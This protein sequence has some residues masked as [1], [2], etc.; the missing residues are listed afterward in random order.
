[1]TCNPN[2]DRRHVLRAAAVLLA[3]SL[4]GFLAAVAFAKTPLELVRQ[5]PKPKFRSGHTLPPLT[6]WGYPLPYE[7]K[8]EMTENWGYALELGEC[9]T[10]EAI[11][12]LDDSKS[13]PAKVLALCASNPKRYPL[14]VLT[15]RP[16]FVP[17]FL[18][19]LPESAWCHDASGKRLPGYG[20][21]LEPRALSPEAPDECFQKAGEIVGE[22]LK[23][24]RRKAPIAIVLNGGEYGMP[25]FGFGGKIWKQD[26]KVVK[27]VG[28]RSWSQY[29]GE[30]RARHEM[31][32]FRAVCQQV[33]DRLLYIDYPFSVCQ[34]QNHSDDWWQWEYAY[35][36]VKAVTD[37][38]GASLY[39]GDYNSG[40]TG[41]NDMLTQ[42][43]N[44]VGGQIELKQPL[45]YN[46]LC[47]GYDRAKPSTD[48]SDME[49]YMGYLKCLYTAGTIGGVA[50]Y[51]SSPKGAFGADLGD[52]MPSWLAQQLTLSHAHALFSHLEEFLR[53]GDL[54]PGPDM[55][56]WSKSQPA[57]EFPTG[58]ADARVLARRHSERAEW[59]LTAWAAGGNDR[60]VSVEILE[61]GTVK[62]I[63]RKCGSVYRA[64]LQNGRAVLQLIDTNGMNPTAAL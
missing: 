55:H 59:L 22:A 28:I 41:S 4:A 30:Q 38:P 16:F 35:R 64:K 42:T 46:W 14:C 37:M 60:E 12:A 57:Y 18:D 53:Q 3:F 36:S 63:A 13:E 17:K 2:V 61:L 54:L 56:R 15:P 43:L 39:Y 8:I 9:P 26:P 24:V 29:L 45:S 21:R 31:P 19:Q 33:P 40:W 23:A 32:V 11:K 48:F 27:G 20:D 47:A 44:A 25:V 34:Y 50:G 58:D 1:M 52:T 49:H 62:L 51:F 6:R 7:L 10:G 5:Q